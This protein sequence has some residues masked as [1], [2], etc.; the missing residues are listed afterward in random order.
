MI[1]K[2]DKIIQ[3]PVTS[4]TYISQECKGDEFDMQLTPV[5]CAGFNLV[6]Y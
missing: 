3:A 2:W 1:L 6:S 4:V 5:M